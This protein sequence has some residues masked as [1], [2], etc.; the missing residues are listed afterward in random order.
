MRTLGK[1]VS[2]PATM[3][4]HSLTKFLM[5]SSVTM[6]KEA[7]MKRITIFLR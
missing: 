4:L 1:L 5:A 6:L 2:K 3:V 7:S